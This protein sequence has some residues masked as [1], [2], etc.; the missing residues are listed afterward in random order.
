MSREK[1]KVYS[2]LL[3]SIKKKG[4]IHF[5]LID[6]E[7]T[8]PSE[9]S[10][11]ALTAENAGSTAIMVGGSLGV[12]EKMTDEVVLAIKRS[13]VGIPVIL[14]PGGIS[15]ISKYADAIWFLSVLN[16]SSIYH[17]IGAQMQGAII[18]K[19]YGLEAISLAYLILGKGGAAGYVSY[20][21]PIPFDHPE[22]AAA[23]A[24]AAKYM[25]FKFVY[26]EGGS[27]G[28]PV[29]P[30]VIRLVKKISEMPVIVGGG[31]KTR[32]LAYNAARA[33]ADGIVTGTVIEESQ[34]LESILK[35]ILEGIQSGVKDRTKN[36]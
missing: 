11:I 10:K 31:I 30:A 36:Q 18:V 24:L 19:K 3:E 35:E 22:L 17:I 7:K 12:S 16:T 8:S 14:F 1:S 4:C 2:Y 26:L 21:R 34:D 20:S 32:Q 25:G 29:P 15:G 13:G 33:G 23:Y 27:G 5:V 6:P 9:A 28:D